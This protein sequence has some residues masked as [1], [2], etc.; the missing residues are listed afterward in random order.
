M[1]IVSISAWETT[2]DADV[3]RKLIA[4]LTDAVVNT[5]GEDIRPVTTVL[6]DA[7]PLSR[8]GSGG[9]PATDFGA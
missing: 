6:I 2:L 9:R 5:F 4:E 8:W 1:P 7:V 3:E